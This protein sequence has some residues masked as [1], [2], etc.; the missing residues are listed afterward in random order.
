MTAKEVSQNSAAWR[1]IGRFLFD[2]TRS[3]G[4]YAAVVAGGTLLFLVGSSIVG[5]LAYSDR[6]GP[7]WGRGI[8]SWSEVKFFIGWLP[9]LIYFLVYLGAVLFPFARLLGWL[10]APRW[11]LRVFAGLFAGIAALVGVLAS[12]WYIAIS[13]YAAFAGALSGMIY[14]AVFLPRFS[15]VPPSSPTSW[16]QWTVIASTIIACGAIVLYPLLP[17]QPERTEQSLEVRFVRVVPGPG[18]FAAD[19]KTGDLTPDE[20]KLLKSLGLSG[21]LQF[22]MSENRGNESRGARAVIVF[23]GELHSRAELRE[24]LRTHVVYIEQGD[25]WKMYPPNAPTIQNKI[26]FWPST[27]D[28]TKIEVQ[29]DPAIGQP[30]AFSWFPPQ[31]SA[32]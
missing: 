23:T 19:A 5:Y 14:G 30:N 29:S 10:R 18:D 2:W 6:P 15:E 25:V 9:L 3:L 24:P 12:G 28:P 17:K 16:K 4:L 1:R 31:P 11:L 7:G 20:L 8:F 13:Q 27:L 32:R 21:T 26:E 22:G